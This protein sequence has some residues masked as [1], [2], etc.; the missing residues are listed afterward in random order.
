MGRRSCSSDG[1][2]VMPLFSDGCEDVELE[3]L[4]EELAEAIAGPRVGGD[5][6]DPTAGI[7]A[8]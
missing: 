3:H 7:F 8:A 2:A 4:V 1:V 5:A 6:I